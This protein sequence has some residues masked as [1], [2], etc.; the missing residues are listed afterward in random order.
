MYTH[1]R[2]RSL[3][4]AQAVYLKRELVV[5][6]QIK[7]LDEFFDLLPTGVIQLAQQLLE[8]VLWH[9]SPRSVCEC[10]SMMSQ[11][12]MYTPRRSRHSGQNRSG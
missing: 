2:M 8:F 12:L 6:V 9:S 7:P 3:K 10:A 4:E 1:R 11:G 5:T